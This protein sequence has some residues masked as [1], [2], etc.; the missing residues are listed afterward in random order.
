M[1]LRS[2][3][4]II[5]LLFVGEVLSV[6]SSDSP[7][8]GVFR[9]KPDSYFHVT[10]KEPYRSH[11]KESLRY[12]LLL[13]KR[14]YIKN[15]FCML[16]LHWANKERNAIVFWDEGKIL[17]TWEL[18][19]VDKDYYYKSLALG[20]LISL[21]D[22]VFPLSEILKHPYDYIQA[23]SQEDIDVLKNE[24]NRYGEKVSVHAFSQP[25]KCDDGSEV[26]YAYDI[27]NEHLCDAMRLR[28]QE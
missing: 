5:S 21:K 25:Q 9:D 24:C 12:L 27:K 10:I 8:F 17:F 2:V 20:D 28:N 19:G 23:Y 22:D 15:N 6:Q 16:G 4:S 18:E 7:G 13:Y 3:I 26:E 11:Y 1:K 14:N